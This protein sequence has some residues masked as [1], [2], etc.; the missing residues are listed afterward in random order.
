MLGPRRSN[1]IGLAYRCGVPCLH[2]F[3]M[4]IDCNTLPYLPICLSLGA[5]II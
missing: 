2:L 4:M 3:P 5:I 1:G